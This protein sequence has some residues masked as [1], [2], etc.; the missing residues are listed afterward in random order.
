MRILLVDDSPKHRKAGVSDLT[1]LGHEVVALSDYTEAR[2][3][4]EDG[5]FDAALLDL[6]MPAEGTT[7][8]GE[9]L[10]FFGQPFAVG[11]PLAMSMALRGVRFVAVAT[12]T[13]HHS[14][15][16]SAA[17]DWFHGEPFK[18]EQSWVLLTHAPLRPDGAKDWVK[19]LNVVTGEWSEL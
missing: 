7:L 2:R 16:A 1:A 17:M 19:I 9:G 4:V 10:A 11:F 3:V 14:H 13:N 12:D 5:G 15:P 18:V 8:G 6:L